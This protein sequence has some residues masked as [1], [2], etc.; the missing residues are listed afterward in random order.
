MTP[1]AMAGALQRMPRTGMGSGRKRGIS[2]EGDQRQQ[3]NQK[4]R[5]LLASDRERGQGDK[6]ST[7]GRGDE[8]TPKITAGAM[9]RMPRT[10]MGSGFTRGNRGEGNGS[11]V[12]STN[13]MH[14]ADNDA[15]HCSKSMHIEK[16]VQDVVEH[17]TYRRSLRIEFRRRAAA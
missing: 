5:V 1:K 11:K 14:R 17:T 12:Q 8:M 15:G 7:K 10:G 6:Q 16:N 13:P 3:D 2:G 4:R 9:Q